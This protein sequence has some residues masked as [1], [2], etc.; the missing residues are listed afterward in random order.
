MKKKKLSDNPFT[1]LIRVLILIFFVCY[2]HWLVIVFHQA[3]P[4]NVRSDEHKLV[5]EL[6][7]V[8]L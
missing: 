3:L 2:F 1:L 4:L 8:S 7:K 5:T 6:N